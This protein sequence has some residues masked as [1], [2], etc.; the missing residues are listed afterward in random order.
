MIIHIILYIR[1]LSIIPMNKKIRTIGA[2]LLFTVSSMVA[3]SDRVGN[4]PDEHGCRAS[5]GYTYSIVKKECVRLFEQEIQLDEAVPEGTSISSAT[6]ILNEDGKKAEVFIPGNLSGIVL[7]KVED[8]G[9]TSWKK[10]KLLLLK[11]DKGYILKKSKKIIFSSEKQA[12]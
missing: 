11:G 8:A 1:P 6:V 7:V 3:Q 10:G 2:F 5:A 4:D 12:G 9:N